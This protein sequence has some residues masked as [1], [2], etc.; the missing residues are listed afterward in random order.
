MGQA[1]AMNTKLQRRIEYFND[2]C[3]LAACY[4]YFLFSDFVPDPELR[5]SIGY[6]SISIILINFGV[7]VGII[8]L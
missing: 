2:V 8:L 7:N 6:G 3:L 1:N 5:Y 4:H